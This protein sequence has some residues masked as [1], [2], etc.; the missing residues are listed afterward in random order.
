MEESTYCNFCGVRQ[1]A[2]FQSKLLKR[3]S[4][5][6]KIAG[7]CGGIGEYFGVDATIVRLIWLALSVFPG[8]I[9]GGI[10]AYI[11]A[12]IVIPV[13]TPVK[14]VAEVPLKPHAKAS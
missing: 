5:D 9:V 11:L 6:C 2:L 13:S 12:W 8:G 3:S 14:A 1:R 4:A 10:V 7:V